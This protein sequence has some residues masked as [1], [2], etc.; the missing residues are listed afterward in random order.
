MLQPRFYK[1]NSTTI[2]Q[3]IT[4]G[5]MMGTIT[6]LGGSV[7]LFKKKKECNVGAWILAIVILLI[8]IGALN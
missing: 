5:R 4:C 6:S 7:H 2:L 3:N 1:R 8:I